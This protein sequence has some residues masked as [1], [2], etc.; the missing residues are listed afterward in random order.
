MCARFLIALLFLSLFG[1]Q[2]FAFIGIAIGDDPTGGVRFYTSDDVASADLADEA[3]TQANLRCLEGKS[4]NCRN[5]HLLEGP[6][7]FATAARWDV[8]R[9]SNV[10]V[11]YFGVGKHVD[12]ARQVAMAACVPSS[13]NSPCTIVFAICHVPAQVPGGVSISV[14]PSP[15]NDT[16][17]E[18]LSK[19]ADRFVS[20]VRS[21]L[22][23]YNPRTVAI[24]VMALS[25]VIFVM[26]QLE[27]FLR[28]GRHRVL[29]TL[30]NAAAAS[31]VAAG[32]TAF[33]FIAQ[34]ISPRA[35]HFLIELDTPGRVLLGTIVVA[36]ILFSLPLRFWQA[37]KTA[38]G[39]PWRF[40]LALSERF[41]K[42]AEARA[43]TY[44]PLAPLSH[45][46][47]L[48]SEEI[49]IAAEAG[50]MLLKIKKS[51]TTSLWGHVI[52][53]IDARMEISAQEHRLV[54]KYRLGD[55]LIYSSAARDKHLDAMK[56]NVEGT[57]GHP[58]FTM[59][60]KDQ[61]MGVLRTLFSF[62]MAGAHATMAAYHLKITVYKLLRGVHVRCKSMGEVLVAKNAIVEAGQNLRTYLDVAQTFDGTEE[63]H[64]F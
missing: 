46:S 55:L 7:C 57:K 62:A 53:M 10:Q 6:G 31:F 47:E 52:F 50:P 60:V 37:V 54:Q 41:R 44:P 14:Q 8:V 26:L 36:V 49:P 51:Q 32:L 34:F 28:T 64:E 63:V 24:S 59:S 16:F 20:D 23:E 61:L 13:S 43:G 22:S 21:F 3:M 15:D 40:D 45:G 33:F 48:A 29:Q 35:Q 12:E 38:H 18:W 2:S 4:I 58:V 17:Y 30:I 42:A 5:L 27:H 11:L 25:I 1:C 39:S 9:R 56:A 19:S